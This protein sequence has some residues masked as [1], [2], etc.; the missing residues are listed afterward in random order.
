MVVELVSV[1]VGA[2]G[3]AAGEVEN[4]TSGGNEGAIYFVVNASVAK[5]GATEDSVAE[6]FWSP[7]PPAFW[8]LEEFPGLAL[9]PKWLRKSYS[10]FDQYRRDDYVRNSRSVPVQ[11]VVLHPVS[12]PRLCVLLRR[13]SYYR[14]RIVLTTCCC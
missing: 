8:L 1:D 13:L 5:A 4:N 9:K 10:S 14:Y 2:D 11:A 12:A 6:P 3:G 7:P